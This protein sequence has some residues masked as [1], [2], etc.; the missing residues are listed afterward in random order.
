MQLAARE[1][2]MNAKILFSSKSTLVIL[3]EKN[4]GIKTNRFFTHCST[5]KSFRNFVIRV[6][7]QSQK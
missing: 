4:K 3:P 2:I 6:I 7:N 5:R 1:K